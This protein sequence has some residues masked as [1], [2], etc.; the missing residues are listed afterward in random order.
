VIGLTLDMS[1][2]EFW[3]RF[4]AATFATWRIVHLLAYEDGP[5]DLLVRLRAWLGQRFWAK[6][7]DCFYCLSIW[8][9]A[10]FAP[11][12]ICRFPEVVLIWLA[13]SGATCL[14][15]RGTASSIQIDHSPPKTE[16]FV[17]RQQ[18]DE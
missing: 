13:L 6:L 4:A 17:N 12:V 3:A 8:V 14:L 15:E 16:D 10:L 18:P 2:G 11:V 9:A 5:W 7:M 1:G